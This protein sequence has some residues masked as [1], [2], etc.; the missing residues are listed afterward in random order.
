MTFNKK[1]LE[2]GSNKNFGIFF[3][4]IFFIIFLWP[5]LNENELRYWSLFVSLFF[6]SFS[7]IKF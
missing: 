4:I 6:F 7:N 1:K 5:L 3:S 2:I